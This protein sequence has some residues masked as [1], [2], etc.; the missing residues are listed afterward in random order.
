MIYAA[1][2][3]SA[4]SGLQTV[5]P[6]RL[7][8]LP[9]SAPLTSIRHSVHTLVL[10]HIALYVAL[11]IGL[12]VIL[13]LHFGLH[14][15]QNRADLYVSAQVQDGVVLIIYTDEMRNRAT[16]QNHSQLEW[17]T[18]GDSVLVKQGDRIEASNG[19]V[20]LTYLDGS[21]QHISQAAFIMPALHPV[22]SNNRFSIADWF[23]RI[24]TGVTQPFHQNITVASV[25]G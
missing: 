23:T 17:L 6:I 18:K 13:G 19:A 22:W 16:R 4:F 2:Q 20:L 8:M 14:T 21:V 15:M 24:I 5:H 1:P 9:N 25:L 7:P 12:F 11:F 3:T 10:M